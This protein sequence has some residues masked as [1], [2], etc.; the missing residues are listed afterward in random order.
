MSD[1]TVTLSEPKVVA[2]LVGI[3]T[4]PIKD[5][6]GAG[7]SGLTKVRGPLCRAT[8]H[9]EDITYILIIGDMQLYYTIDSFE[10]ASD[11]H[12]ETFGKTALNTPIYL[13]LAVTRQIAA[14]QWDFSDD[15]LGLDGQSQA[16]SNLIC[17]YALHQYDVDIY[18][19]L[20]LIPGK[21]TRSFLSCWTSRF[22]DKESACW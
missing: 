14:R 1:P 13:F 22:L 8:L 15:F 2:Q 9:S 21:D 11:M 4:E 20:P 3:M 5:P 12:Y 18:Q 10:I 17:E 19:C 7:I 6:F 16:G